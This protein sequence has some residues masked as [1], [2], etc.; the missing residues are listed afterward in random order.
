MS[1]KQ[2]YYYGRLL[3]L[4]FVMIILVIAANQAWRL[5]VAGLYNHQTEQ[6][7]S[8]WQDKKRKQGEGFTMQAR[9]FV[10]ALKGAEKGIEQLPD[11]A[12]QWI[13][14]A[15]I[16]SWGEEYLTNN[17]VG[18][19]NNSS[20]YVWR[21]AVQRRPSWPYAWSDYAMARAQ[22]SLI[23]DDFERALIRAN[24]LG[25]WER[26]VMETSALLGTH[27]KGWLSSHLQEHLDVSLKR[28]AMVHPA[29]ARAISVGKY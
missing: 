26:D 10:V 28:L 3:L 17:E 21:Q 24:K 19:A 20:L 12:E 8:F 14:K 5:V 9:N 29:K 18:A 2:S 27:Y 16:L 15:R 22:K 1:T 7:L 11:S 25:P 13:L 23:D 6:Y 4:S